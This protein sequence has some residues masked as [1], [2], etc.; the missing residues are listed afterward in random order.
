MPA[1]EAADA[2]I[3]KLHPNGLHFIVLD[4]FSLGGLPFE[5]IK[6][7]SVLKHVDMLL[8][9]SA[10]DLTRNLDKYIADG[11]IDAFAPGWREAVDHKSLGQ[12]ATKDP[13]V[14]RGKC[15]TPR[16]ISSDAD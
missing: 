11:T 5:L 10:M 7:F 2:V 13:P 14:I 8:H 1:L 16:H 4:P 9:V 3:A 6:K 12:E 15:K